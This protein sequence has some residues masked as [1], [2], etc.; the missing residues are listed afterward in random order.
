MRV[1][2]WIQEAVGNIQKGGGGFA[3]GLSSGS[4]DRERVWIQR[5]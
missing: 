2:K 1:Y 5:P 3:G 4:G